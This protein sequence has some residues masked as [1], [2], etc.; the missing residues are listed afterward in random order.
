MGETER[1]VERQKTIEPRAS[2]CVECGSHQDWNRH[3]KTWTPVLGFILAYLAFVVSIAPQIS[4]SFAPS[5]PKMSTQISSVSARELSTVVSYLGERRVQAHFYGPLPV[6]F[7]AMAEAVWRDG[8]RAVVGTEEP[9]ERERA[10]EQ[11][12]RR[13]RTGQAYPQALPTGECMHSLRGKA[14]LS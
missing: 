6:E 4:S 14:K 10:I 5:P 8:S 11:D 2:L 9:R 1:C 12:R 3:I 7:R 13:A